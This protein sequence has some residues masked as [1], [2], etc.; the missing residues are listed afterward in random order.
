MTQ[1]GRVLG[2]W[3]CLALVVGNLIGSGIYLLPA[4]MA[5]FGWNALVGWIVTIGGALCIAHMFARLAAHLPAAGGPYAYTRAAFGHGP[6]F[7]VAWVYWMMVWLGNGAVA[8]AVVSALSL[9]FPRIG[10]VPGLPAV[11]SLA[12]VW[13]VTG[14]NIRGAEIVGRVQF[15]TT[16]LKLLPLLAVVLIAAALLGA[17][18]A[19]AVQPQPD[20][21]LGMGTVTAAAAL[22]FWGFTGL[23]SA[24]VPADRIENPRVNIP[25]ATL[26]GTALTGL[27]YIL[28]STAL[29]LLMPHAQLAAS[30]APV[31]EFIGDHWGRGM[32]M[33]VAL[34]AA[35]S[36]FGT[37]NGYILVQGEMPWAMAKG[38]VFPRWLDKVGRHGTPVR[39]HLVSSGL[40]TAVT[41]MNFFRSTVDLFQFIVLVATAAGLLAYFACALAALKLLHREA[42]I[43]VTAP[44]AGIFSLWAIYGCG[45]QAMGWGVVLLLLGLPLYFWVR[46][47]EKPA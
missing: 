2:F 44:L 12:L 34:F 43:R 29:S 33:V 35:I 24:T 45:W 31:A 42:L 46:L 30:P 16:V 18:G 19:A 40:L 11:L 23:E 38:G 1:A 22:A 26:I 20:V 6:A 14:I 39:A 9:I 8:V 41:L 13:L 15:V 17:G 4:S 36:A 32:G 10:S 25:R 28:V 5:P 3:T 37:L 7:A 47:T 27:V 21:P